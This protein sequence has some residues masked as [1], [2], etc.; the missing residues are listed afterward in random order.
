MDRRTQ[1]L[2]EIAHRSLKVAEL[3]KRR[4]V[5]QEALSEAYRAFK[6]AHKIERYVDRKSEEWQQMIRATAGE[7]GVLQESKRVV[8]NARKRLA[9]SI[10]K[11]RR[12][13]FEL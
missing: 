2:L 1:L 6:A 7:A 8:G 4:K 5:D 11:Y 12:V 3:D 13:E 9:G 10:A